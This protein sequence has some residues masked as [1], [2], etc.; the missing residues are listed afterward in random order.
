MKSK[1]GD[2]SN[3]WIGRKGELYAHR[4]VL[5]GST[6]ETN[7]NR[8]S[9]FDLLWEGYRINVKVAKL[10]Y[11]HRCY[12]YIFKLHNHHDNCDFF[13][14]MGYKNRRD[15]DFLQ[16]WLIP[17]TMITHSDTGEILK[18]L[19]I[20]AANKGRFKNYIM[21]YQKRKEREEFNHDQHRGEQASN[22]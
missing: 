13:L 4:Y 2:R 5:I 10:V 17:A 14:L 16:V 3:A 20:G 22:Y 9:S 6:L 8:N 18:D 7:K 19:T 21:D 15:K 1:Y 11:H 12:S